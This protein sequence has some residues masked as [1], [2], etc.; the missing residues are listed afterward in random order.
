MLVNLKG[1]KHCGFANP[2]NVLKSVLRKGEK[3]DV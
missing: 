3:K 1:A 2:G